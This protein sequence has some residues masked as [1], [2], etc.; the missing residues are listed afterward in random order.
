[1]TG[2]PEGVLHVLRRFAYRFVKEE[3]FGVWMMIDVEDKSMTTLGSPSNDFP[4][5]VVSQLT[6]DD[7]DRIHGDAL[8][9]DYVYHDSM[10]TDLEE[11][12]VYYVCDSIPE[13]S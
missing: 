6:A 4:G 12:I 13:H 10:Y 2:P 7:G 9:S 8:Y 5:L 1:M 3:K 11:E